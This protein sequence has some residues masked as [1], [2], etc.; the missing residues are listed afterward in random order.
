MMTETLIWWFLICLL[1]GFIVS[2]HVYRNY[3]FYY[4]IIVA[5]VFA[6]LETL[7]LYVAIYFYTN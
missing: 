2:L 4:K 3:N 7:L 1:I 6:S 5:F